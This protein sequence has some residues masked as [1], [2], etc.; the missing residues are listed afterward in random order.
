MRAARRR[1]RVVPDSVVLA[2]TRE[3]YLKARGAFLSAVNKGKQTYWDEITA[4]IDE[5]TPHNR[6]KPNWARLKRVMHNTLKP[7]TSCVDRDGAPPLSPACTQQL[8]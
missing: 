3:T 6:H 7:M 5:T 4:A 2:S 1:G 8:S